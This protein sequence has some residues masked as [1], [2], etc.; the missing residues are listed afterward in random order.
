MRFTTLRSVYRFF[1][2]VAIVG[3]TDGTDYHGY[4]LT[5]KFHSFLFIR[6]HPCY[7]WLINFRVSGTRSPPLQFTRKYISTTPLTIRE[8]AQQDILKPL[9][10]I[11]PNPVQTG[12][13][14]LRVKCRTLSS[15]SEGF[16]L[17]GSISV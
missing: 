7:P 16:C 8:A 11:N 10:G 4:M 6:V 12:Q 1:D 17:N 13:Y 3:T 14:H 15:H 9:I 5:S 2:R